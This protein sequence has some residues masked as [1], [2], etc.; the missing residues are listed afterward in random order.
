MLRE[1]VAEDERDIEAMMTADEAFEP[2]S[3]SHDVPPAPKK[4]RS[5]SKTDAIIAAAAEEVSCTAHIVEQDSQE[6]VITV[7][8]EEEEMATPDFPPIERL[9]KLRAASRSINP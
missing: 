8:D 6:L 2:S 7:D 4:R 1:Q 5:G 9:A 3:W